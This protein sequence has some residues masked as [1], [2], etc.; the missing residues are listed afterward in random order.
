MAKVQIREERTRGR[1]VGDT[2]QRG[3][4]KEATTVCTPLMK[5]TMKT[6]K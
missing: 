5:M 6:L 3:V 1:R 2:L 4:E